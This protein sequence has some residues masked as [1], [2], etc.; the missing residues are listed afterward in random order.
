MLSA[1]FLALLSIIRRA[2]VPV[3]EAAEFTKAVRT[4]HAGATTPTEDDLTGM[5]HLAEH[6]EAGLE[7]MGKDVPDEDE[8]FL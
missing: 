3:I 1:L 7:A 4:A 5:P 6:P 2:Q 8:D